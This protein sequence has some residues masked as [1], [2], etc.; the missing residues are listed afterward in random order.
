MLPP[1]TKPGIRPISAPIPP[2]G[3]QAQPAVALGTAAP[4]MDWEQALVYPSPRPLRPHRTQIPDPAVSE[5]PL[6][7]RADGRSG[8]VLGGG[9][10]AVETDQ[11]VD[12]VA[13]PPAGDPATRRTHRPGQVVA[14]DGRPALRPGELAGRDGGGADL[15]QQLARPWL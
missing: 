2:S 6:H 1:P 13:G 9:T 5:L 10:R 11:A 14:R 7:G 3:L 12:I 8:D 4:S 15:N